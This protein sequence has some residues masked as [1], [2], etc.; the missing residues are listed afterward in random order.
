MQNQILI[1]DDNPTNT[2][3]L[4]DCLK[5]AGYRILI[6]QSGESAIEKLKIASPD[7][8][9]LDVMMPGINGFETCQYLKSTS[10]TQNIPIIFMTALADTEEKIQ[11]FSLGAVDYITKPFQQEEVLAR[12][13]THLQ[14]RNLSKQMQTLNQELEQRVIERT[15]ELT[16]ALENLQ[17]SQL[18]LVQSE[19]MS[20]LGNLVAGV[21][22][23]INNPIGF[24]SGNINQANL[25][26]QDI[27]DCLRLYQEA[28][29]NPSET[30]QNKIAEV[31]LEYLIEDL[32]KMINSMEIG[33]DRI[34]QI[35][36]SLRTFSRS[37]SNSKIPANIHEGID[38]TL[39]ILQHRL[40]ANE[41]RPAIQIIKN[42]GD[43]PKVECYLGQLNQVFMNIF[44]NAIDSFDDINKGR[45]YLEIELKPNIITIATE[46]I[47]DQKQNKIGIMIKIQD[48]GCGMTEDIKNRIFDN[49]YTTKNIGQGTGL[50]LSI[51]RQII[52]E[53]HEGKIKVESELSKGSE[54]II[55]LP[56][57]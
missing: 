26:L 37:D 41:I 51:S 44:A 13:N 24:I 32:P 40:K 54:F 43:I 20:S 39:M 35:S 8:I 53:K 12:I 10:A 48:N 34:R 50:G 18:Q 16:T 55:T 45:K 36:T 22:H 21:A 46:M 25:A 52:E 14:L 38:S 47:L 30:I 23:E 2:K 4:F 6:A 57:A 31:E 49:L 42:Y 33:C 3:V 11:G 17:K 27:V 5:S 9:L 56:I 28:L 19:K 1:V 15:S 29:P 7:L